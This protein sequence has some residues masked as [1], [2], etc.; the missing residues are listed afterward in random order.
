MIVSFYMFLLQ[1]VASVTTFH[2]SKSSPVSSSKL[3]IVHLVQY[4][5]L[6]IEYM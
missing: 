1:D 6:C 2:A 4:K 3:V 5:V